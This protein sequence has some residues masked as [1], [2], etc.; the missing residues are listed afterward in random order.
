MKLALLTAL[1]MVAFAANSVLNRLALA[2]GAIDP[3]SFAALRIASG[4]AILWAMVLWRRGKLTFRLGGVLSLVAYMIGFSFAYV[5]L[6]T[7]IGAL[8]LFGGVQVTMFLGALIKREPVSFARW[9]GALI[10]FAGLIVL[11]WPAEDAKVPLAGTVLMVVAAVG[12]GIYSL[13]GKGAAD[14]IASTASNFVYALPF[15]ALALAFAPTLV[16][17]VQGVLL[18]VLSGAVT[19]GLGYALW[20]TILPRMSA[21]LAAI[22]MLTVP[23]IATAGGVVFLGE[24]VGLRFAIA[25]GLV[26][27]GVLVAAQPART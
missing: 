26:L 17:S 24:T 27:G 18:A 15:G 11:V 25:T 12:W 21:S 14:P 22:V 9:S 13:L 4:G 16:V 19:S 20:Y 10:A 5:S 7:G 23:V 8:I 6:D 3:A 1:T 2:D